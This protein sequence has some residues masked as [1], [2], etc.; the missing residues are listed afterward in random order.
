MVC[1]LDS[2]NSRFSQAVL[3]VYIHGR[4]A[5]RYT[6]SLWYSH[7]MLVKWTVNVAILDSG[8]T[9]YSVTQVQ[10]T[11]LGLARNRIRRIDG[12]VLRVCGCGMNKH[13]R[14]RYLM[15]S[16]FEQV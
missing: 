1:Y 13:E 7:H 2:V 5:E 3:I 12:R 11:S 4:T 14:L 8:L 6:V 15:H 9:L 10:Q 16:P